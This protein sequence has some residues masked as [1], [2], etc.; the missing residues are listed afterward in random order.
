MDSKKPDKPVKYG[1]SKSPP[2][3]SR[4]PPS[5][6]GYGGPSQSYGNDF[7]SPSVPGH[8]HDFTPIRGG[9][10]SAGYSYSSS[11]DGDNRYNSYDDY[12]DGPSPVF[13]QYSTGPK[14]FVSVSSHLSGD[15]DP[16]GGV[17]NIDHGRDYDSTVD[18]PQGYPSPSSKNSPSYSGGGG[19]SGRY[20]YHRAADTSRPS[21]NYH[22]TGHD[23]GDAYPRPRQGY[24]TKETSAPSL[25]PSSPYYSYGEDS[26]EPSPTS[27][28]SR[29][30]KN[31]NPG[32]SGRGVGKDPK[33]KAY[34]RM[35]YTQNV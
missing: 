28:E 14:S 16:E 2:Y 15:E 7:T 9:G 33:S 10:G 12:H 5:H 17:I 22:S 29:L 4:G 13:N 18:R 26:N 30:A 8:G 35:S 27:I 32:N 1:A 3:P 20:D 19:K 11:P 24:Q 34:W 25:A 6:P 23:A 21:R 31:G